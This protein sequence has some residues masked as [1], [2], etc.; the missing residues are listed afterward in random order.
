MTSGPHISL[1]SHHCFEMEMV[2]LSP[3]NPCLS[4]APT[5]YK[6]YYVLQRTRVPT[7]KP[8]TNP[9]LRP[10]RFQHL[11]CMRYV[12]SCLFFRLL[13]LLL[14]WFF[15]KAK[16]R[17]IYCVWRDPCCVS[18]PSTRGNRKYL[19]VGALKTSSA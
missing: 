8:R 12:S 18:H 11:D 14:L 3:L 7:E 4:P 15:L 2:I 5:P 13:L 19:P 10:L 16:N 17:L 9:D 1:M 6:W